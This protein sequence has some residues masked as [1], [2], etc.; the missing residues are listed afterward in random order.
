MMI[1]TT[2]QKYPPKCPELPGPIPQVTPVRAVIRIASKSCAEAEEKSFLPRVWLAGGGVGGAFGILVLLRLFRRLVLPAILAAFP[3]GGTWKT[4]E[5][6]SGL[7]QVEMPGKPTPQMKDNH[8]LYLCDGK[9][10]GTATGFAEYPANLAGKPPAEIGSLLVRA[11]RLQMQKFDL[12]QLQGHP[13]L[14]H[15]SS[16]KGVQNLTRVVL[17]PEGMVDLELLYKG[18][19]P[20]E[21]R[22]RFFNS[23]RLKSPAAPGVPPVATPPAPAA[24]TPPPATPLSSTPA[25]PTA[26]DAQSLFDI[27]AVPL[28]EFPQ[29]GTEKI[30][31]GGVAVSQVD[32]ATANRGSNT[33]G[34][35][36]SLRVYRP[37]GTVEDHS[38]PCI[39]VAPAGTNLMVGNNL[40]DEDYHD[41]TL[42][43]ALSGMVVVAYSLDGGIDLKSAT[44]VQLLN[45]DQQFRSAAA[46]VVNG[47]N[48]LEFALEQLPEVDPNRI[49]SAGHSSAGTLSLLLAEHESR[50]AGC[51]AYAPCTDVPARLQQFTSLPESK[52]LPGLNAFLARS[53]PTT[54]ID[55]INCRVFLFHA[56]DD[57]NT[58]ISESRDFK[59]RLTAAGKT[60]R[61][62]EASSG[63]H[64]DSMVKEWIPRAIEWL[65]QSQPQR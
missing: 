46:G 64:D 65:K 49:Y 29:L 52:I 25:T 43:Y 9:E 55:Q 48:A 38:L 39:L 33:P 3:A 8:Q 42:P 4:F 51:I 61:L 16:E 28:P 17:I 23:F 14:E 63:D 54:H 57:T 21:V 44:N 1:R 19:E 24:A 12:I 59:N 27:N 47:R 62:V 53:S 40:D 5:H 36:M 50:L 11:A 35:G 32:L 15:R 34:S 60:V 13:A 10:F 45:A 31:P 26:E 18:A 58:P 56:Q 20:A 2:P 7:Y 22:D 41:E 37:V 6:P 30:L